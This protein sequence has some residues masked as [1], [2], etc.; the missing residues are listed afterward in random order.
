MNT[1]LLSSNLQLSTGLFTGIVFGFL[2]QKG[3]LTSF[4]V[5]VGQL[6][7]KNFTMMK[8]MLTAIMVGSIGI[9]GL[10]AFNPAYT[11]MISSTT[12][13]AA[14]LG[15]SIF[16]I[17]MATLGYCPGTAMAALGD[18]RRDVIFGLLG[19][20]F[21]AG[22]YAELF[23]FITKQIKSTDFMNQETLAT[24]TGISPWIFIAGFVIIFGIGFY[25]LERY[26]PK[27]K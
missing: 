10:I 26:L 7:F 15:G 17:G 18:G 20:V 25:M 21:G 5:I 6:I 13:M 19:M 3:R 8:V 12:L 2:L 23:P 1:A 24:I 4:D 14:F 11:T 27:N 22:I 9:Y 16:A